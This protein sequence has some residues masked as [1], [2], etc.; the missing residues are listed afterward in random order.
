MQC[1]NCG[2][3]IEPNDLFCG[4]CGHKIDKQSQTVNSAEKDISNA[5]ANGRRYD[6]SASLGEEHVT[7]SNHNEPLS[8][9]NNTR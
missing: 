7:T 2:S 5:E 9:T 6:T 1:P 4:E 3:A 8:R